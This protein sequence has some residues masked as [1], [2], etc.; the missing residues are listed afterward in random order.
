MHALSGKS[1][2]LSPA[3]AAALAV[4]RHKI[5]IE[6]LGW[7]LP[8]Q[9]GMER[10]QFDRPDTLYVIARESNG[11]ICGCA[12][13]LPTTQPYL[14]SEVFPELLGDVPRPHAPE[15]WE[16]SRFAA[17]TADT[18]SMLNATI[19]TR[20]LLAAAIS[21]AIA[22]GAKRLITVSPLGV[23]RLL[24]RMGVHAHRA[25]PP[26]K[27]EGKIIFACWIEINA[28]TIGAL[29]VA[30]IEPPACH[31]YPD[32]GQ[33]ILRV[34]EGNVSG[35]RIVQARIVKIVPMLSK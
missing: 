32:F 10:D 1:S 5:F 18:G 22:Q 29:D 26:L 31:I 25:G 21:S 13:L 28:Q 9:D 19:G 3:L 12:R 27:V 14:L 6:R 15:V 8:S 2:E 20:R 34:M 23:E 30:S 17:T 24:R 35:T 4:Y 33:H 7:S 16:L 11:A